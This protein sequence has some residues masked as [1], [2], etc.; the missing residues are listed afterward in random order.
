MLIKRIVCVAASAMALTGC[1]GPLGER[2]LRAV[3][4]YRTYMTE[5]VRDGSM[6]CVAR[7]RVDETLGL[8][9][10]ECEMNV[11]LTFHFSGALEFQDVRVSYKT[12]VSGDWGVDGDTL[13]LM[14]DSAT[15]RTTF[16]GSN[17]SNNVEEAMV[18][19]LRRNVIADIQPRLC[20]QYAKKSRVSMAV[21]SFGDFGV[22]GSLPDSSVVLLQ[23]TN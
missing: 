21:R 10:L 5:S 9:G 8:S 13:R 14:P 2:E 7:A 20:M 22:V 12:L 4:T 15:M 18:R 11:D 17:A 23:R 19:Q 6:R 16:V 3:G 1:G